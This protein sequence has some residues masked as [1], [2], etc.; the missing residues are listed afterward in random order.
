MLRYLY[1]PDNEDLDDHIDFAVNN[2]F[3][4]IIHGKSDIVSDLI[5]D[6]NKIQEINIPEIIKLHND[7]L[8][9]QEGQDFV[10]RLINEFA[11]N[12]KY[13]KI[14][15][16]IYKLN[17]D[18]LTI[19]DLTISPD[20]NIINEIV[21]EFIGRIDHYGEYE[22]NI[23]AILE[24]MSEEILYSDRII[25]YKRYDGQDENEKFFFEG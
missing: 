11:I 9:Y 8:V 5:V 12:Y 2:N 18:D 1:I 20:M 3:Q 23:I 4:Q 24:D 10:I 25:I 6:E 7:F 21:Y 13:N 16:N 14:K 19:K 17:E 15:I 22:F